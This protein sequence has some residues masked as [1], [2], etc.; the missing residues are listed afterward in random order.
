MRGNSSEAQTKGGGRWCRST[1][2]GR[3]ALQLAITLTALLLSA[4]LSAP[5]HGAPEEQKAGEPKNIDALPKRVAR[6][7]RVSYEVALVRLEKVETCRALFSDL[8]AD[9]LEMLNR[10]VYAPAFDREGGCE[11]GSPAYTFIGSRVTR[12]CPVFADLPRSKAA[13]ALLH[14]A[15]HHAGL[16]ER[17]AVPTARHTAKEINWMVARKCGL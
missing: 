13:V 10:S 4:A 6:K 5:A 12:L 15:L 2:A 1:P 11:R 7:L 14:E 16:G 8:G 17:P 9:G 3:P